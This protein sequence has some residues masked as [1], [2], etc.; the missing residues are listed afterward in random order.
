MPLTLRVTKGFE[1]KENVSLAGKD[2]IEF[3]RSSTVAMKH[4]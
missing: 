1:K 3:N 4:V 2:M